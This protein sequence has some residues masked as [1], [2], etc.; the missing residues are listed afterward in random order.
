MRK[1]CRLA[2]ACI[3]AV[4]FTGCSLLKV[5]VS[6]GEPL[7][8]HEND[9]R[10]ATRGFYHTFRSQVIGAADSIIRGTDDPGVKMHAVRWKLDATRTATSAALKTIPELAAL[11]TWVLCR[12]M[13]KT[14]EALPDSALFGE[15][16]YIARNTAG[17]LGGI[18]RKRMA[19]VMNKERFA[20]MDEFV[21]Q[22]SKAA[23]SDALSCLP[24]PSSEWRE[25]LK[26]KGMACKRSVGSVPE[27]IADAGDRMEKYADQASKDLSFSREF[28]EYRFEHDSVYSKLNYRL[29]TME[30]DFN[31]MVSVIECFPEMSD[32]ML[33]SLSMQAQEI[34]ELMNLMVDKTSSNFDY[35]RKE[36]Q[37]YISE[38]RKSIMEGMRVM[39]DDSLR[40]VLDAL[41]GLVGKIA[42]WIILCVTVVFGVPFMAGF[43]LGRL[44]EKH[45]TDKRERNR[46]PE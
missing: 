28:L 8:E 45:R 5:S 6:T 35:Q 12:N 11:E 24:D 27:V 40:T 19:E 36:M 38:E 18:Y 14:L 21:E 29:N 3:I 44:H 34:M 20:L 1:L 13:E 2:V 33:D 32:C 31:R 22:H 43:W 37:R 4:G 26:E 23:T 46:M 10:M 42:V 16:T 41:P 25:Y 15:R 9:I 7:T 30:H 39:A 17:R